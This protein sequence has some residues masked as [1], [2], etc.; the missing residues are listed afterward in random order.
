[1]YKFYYDESEHSRIINLS[2]ITGETYYDNF[3]TAIVGWSSENETN[4]KQKYLAFEEK[5]AER[6]KKGELKSN[7]FKSNQFLYGFASFN[8]PNVQMLNDLLSII[9]E[10]IYIYLSV[11]SKIEYVIIQLFKDYENNIFVDMDLVRYSIVKAILTYRPADVISNIYAEPEKFVAS[12]IDFFN[13]RIELNKKNIILKKVENQEFEK[14]LLVLQD[15]EPP[16]S[17]NWDYHMPFI[18]FDLFLKSK[19]IS[20]YS[21]TLDKEGNNKT[22]NAAIEVGIKNCTE[23][24]STGHF[25]LRIADMLAGIIGKIMKSLYHSLHNDSNN[26]TVSKTLLD[27]KWFILSDNQLQLYKKLY[28]IL[29]DINNNWYKIYAGNYSD[30]LISLLGLLDYMNHFNSAD[31]IKNNFDMHPEYC[32]TCMCSRL[33]KHFKQIHNKLPFEPINPETDE[34]FRNNKGAKV[35]FDINNQPKLQLNNG[36]NKFNVLSV[37]ISKEGIPLVTIESEPENICFRLPY[38]L[39]EWAMKIIEMAN[40]GE[41]LFPSKVI[42]S[43]VNGKYFADIL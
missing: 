41:N 2:T 35:Y 24:D 28:H 1:M 31:E 27:K 6:K 42:F 37:S 39:S 32:N 38:Q 30:D 33:E 34:Y 26:A 25:G 7:T 17:L 36:Q 4:I 19:K 40:M 8:E 15:V 11:S 5:Y 9:D 10:N 3:L 16:I 14:I 23:L 12:L 21:L 20:E 13:E 43:K 22:L 18:G 29:L